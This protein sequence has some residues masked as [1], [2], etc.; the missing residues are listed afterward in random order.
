MAENKFK[1]SIEI[2]EESRDIIASELGKNFFVEASAGSGKTTS[3]VNRMVALIESGVPVDKICT[4]TFTKAAA[5]EFFN[6]FQALLSTRSVIAEGETNQEVIDKAKLCQIALNNIDSCFLGTIDAFCNMIA[7]EL[8]SELG[9][10]S[11]SEIIDNEEYLTL[12]RKKYIDILKDSKDPLHAKA[13]KYKDLMRFDMDGLVLGIQEFLDM[14]H[15]KIIFGK[16]L[17]DTDLDIYFAKEKPWLLSVIK[18]LIDLDDCYN[19]KK[20]GSKND[21]YEYQTSLRATYNSLVKKSWNKCHKSLGFALDRIKKMDGYNTKVIGTDVEQYLNVPL[22][23]A[24]NASLKYTDAFRSD[25]DSMIDKLNDYK[26]SVYCDFVYSMSKVME[27]EFK[28]KGKFQFFDFLYYLNDAFKKS[29][30]G[31]RELI[32]HILTRH[33]HFLLDESQD[34]NPLQTEMFFHLTGTVYD[35]DWKKVKPKEGSL[36]IVGDP[37]QSIYGFRN[38][39]VAAY[40]KNKEIFAQENEVLYLTK[41]FR[42]NVRLRDWFND[43]M[44]DLLNHGIEPLEHPEIPI[45]NEER[46]EEKIPN[47]VIDGV[48]R[49]EVKKDDYGT[50]V[51]KLINSLA[52]KQQI[53]SKNEKGD[54]PKKVERKIRYSDFMIIPKYTNIDSLLKA[55]KDYHIP[56]T[57]EARIPFESSE[58]LVVLK[59]LTLLLKAPHDIGKFLKVIHGKLY[60]F[61]EKEVLMLRNYGFDLN[62]SHPFNCGESKLDT[63]INELNEMY[64]ETYEMS[65]SSTM[66][67]IIN[68]QTFN[69]F[70]R[71][72]ASGLDYTYFLIQKIKEREENGSLSTVNQLE[73]FINNFLQSKDDQRSLRFKDKIDRIKVANV[74]KV[75]GLQA[76]IVVLAKPTEMEKTNNKY[77]DYDL[78]PP[79]TKFSKISK[80][81]GKGEDVYAE[82]KQFDDTLQARNDSTVAEKERLEYVAATRAESVLIVGSAIKSTMANPWG[83]LYTKVDDSYNNGNLNVLDDE[84]EAVTKVNVELGNLNINTDSHKLTH[85]YVSPSLMR[86]NKVNNNNDEI[87]DTDFV[88]EEKK[89]AT[90]LGTMAHRIMELIVSSK[91]TYSDEDLLAKVSNEYD[92]DRRYEKLLKT[93]ITT[94]KNGG[95]EQKSSTLNNDILK[96]LMSAKQAW[97]ETPFSYQTKDGDIISGV[98]DVFYLDQEGKYH[99]IDYK[100]N[101]DN[102]VENLETHYEKQLKSYIYALRKMGIEA[103][104]HIYHIDLNK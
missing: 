49:Y 55:L 29:E 102:N 41:N 78:L 89:D 66:L 11:N 71:I 95:Y 30:K 100:T 52:Y 59:D 16:D 44:N 10:P 6:R 57:I 34:T 73:K 61:N 17:L 82:T 92:Y 74:H 87:D 75:K 63:T 46:A 60:S 9:I 26:Y 58:S 67:Y 84:P 98:I 36:F 99:V 23:P 88:K 43:S 27:A 54:T 25:I 80:N 12:V 37:K 1:T 19:P 35:Q 13:L 39:S 86:T 5:D 32:N 45:S 104:A 2:D 69:I 33:S 68:S 94:I 56:A 77:V 53:Y 76:P 85:K 20:D 24:S 22:N 7:H 4:I 42:S 72:D 81:N 83:D 3:L 96:T 50:Y 79:E 48:Y 70:K 14:R 8:P 18:I 38:A 28:D 21:K 62:I 47:N 65:F 101:D 91:N 40:L 31:D 93:I 51:A 64:K 97:C 103:D 15:T 90:L